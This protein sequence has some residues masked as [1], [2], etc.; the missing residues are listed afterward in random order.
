MLRNYLAWCSEAKKI[1]ENTIHSRMNAMKFLYEQV[2]KREKL[3]LE[4]PRPQ[5]P[6]QLPKVI[7]EEK[8]LRGILTVENLKHRTLLLLAYSCGLRVSEVVSIQ[9]KSIDEDRMQVFIQRAK[10]KKDRVVPLAKSLIPVLKTYK[11]A[12]KPT[13]WLFENQE[14]N[15]PYSSRSA[16]QVF[17]DAANML[18]LPPYISFHSLRHSLAT[19]LLENGIDISLIQKLLGHHDIRTT[20]RY[21]HV[22][23]KQVKGIEN[24]LDAIM[25]K[26]SHA[27][28]SAI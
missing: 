9:V 16:Q 11:E 13:V 19:H 15:G 23:D 27:K 26:N 3:F 22:A 21:T 20:L 4:I 10:G 25:R 28:N 18:Q 5:K 8:I 6:Q 24:P 17:K 14:K 2:L 12:Y 1:S 7:S